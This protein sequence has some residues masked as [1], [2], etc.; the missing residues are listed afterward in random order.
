MLFGPKSESGMATPVPAGGKYPRL[1]KPFFG[2][3]RARR[4]YLWSR[5]RKDQATIRE[6]LEIGTFMVPKDKLPSFKCSAQV[7]SKLEQ[8]SSS[9]SLQS[10]FLQSLK[11]LDNEQ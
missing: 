1:T 5:Y 8:P 3:N 2:P 6:Q 9:T 4:R 11:E 10:L 7:R